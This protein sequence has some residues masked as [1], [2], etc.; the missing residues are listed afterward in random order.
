MLEQISYF[1]DH[2]NVFKSYVYKLVFNKTVIVLKLKWK[3]KLK[4]LN[5]YLPLVTFQRFIYKD[6]KQLFS[7]QLIRSSENC[8]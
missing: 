3:P 5:I 1:I 2:L 7:T 4:I 8:H 6:I